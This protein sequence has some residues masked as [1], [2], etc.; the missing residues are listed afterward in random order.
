M[1]VSGRL[2][3]AGA[4]VA[5]LLAAAPEA[6][7]HLVLGAE[8]HV[9]T[10]RADIVVPGYSVPSLVLWDDDARP[11]LVVGEGGGVS[12]EGKVRVYLNVSGGS[13][14]AFSDFFYAQSLGSDL[15]VPGSG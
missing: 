11:D 10:G 8:E 3:G 12:A 9:Q 7:G 5:A 1:G 15:V 4:T 6:A 2:V 14:P 13:E